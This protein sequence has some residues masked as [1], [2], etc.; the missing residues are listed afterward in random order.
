M[1]NQQQKTAA[2]QINTEN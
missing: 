1:E 2:G